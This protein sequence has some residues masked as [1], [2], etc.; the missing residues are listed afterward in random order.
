MKAEEFKITKP[1]DSPPTRLA[2]P[3]S[4]SGSIASS[5]C[6][7]FP[8]NITEKYVSDFN[9]TFEEFVK[10]KSE[11]GVDTLNRCLAVRK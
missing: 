1:L 11:D 6:T 10:N 4:I 7:D 5:N 8:I 3:S 9:K 2:S